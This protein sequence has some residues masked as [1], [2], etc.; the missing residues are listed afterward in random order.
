MN[1]YLDV[2]MLLMK[3]RSPD[4]GQELQTFIMLLSVMY[5]DPLLKGQ[6]PQF[7][8]LQCVSEYLCIYQKRSI[9][10]SV[11]PEEAVVMSLNG[12]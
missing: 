8:I 4:A 1:V 7:Y 6:L 9:N 11:A 5:S 12:K 10:Y 2:Q 3:L